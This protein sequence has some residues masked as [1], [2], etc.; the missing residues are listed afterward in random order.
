MLENFEHVFGE[1][2]KKLLNPRNS[3]KMIISGTN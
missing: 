2:Q 3:L 1:A